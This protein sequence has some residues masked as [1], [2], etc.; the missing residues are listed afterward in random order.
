M[1]VLRDTFRVRVQASI[2]ESAEPWFGTQIAIS[3]HK[4]DL[5]CR[6]MKYTSNDPMPFFMTL[7]WDYI[8]RR[9]QWVYDCPTQNIVNL[10]WLHF[11]VENHFY[12]SITQDVNFTSIWG[13]FHCWL[14]RNGLKIFKRERFRVVFILKPDFDPQF[15]INAFSSF[16][17][18]REKREG[19]I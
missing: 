18:F 7:L 17:M 16:W 10:I 13:S 6:I 3:D 5:F 11:L 4:T 1:Y 12:A 9:K 15:F 14:G 19:K 2:G 8:E